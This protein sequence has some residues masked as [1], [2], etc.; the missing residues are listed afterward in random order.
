MQM[1]NTIMYVSAIQ[2][3]FPNIVVETSYGQLT[4]DAKEFARKH[5]ETPQSDMDI[6]MRIVDN[7][8]IVDNKVVGTQAELNAFCND[9]VQYFIARFVISGK[10]IPVVTAAEAQSIL[11]KPKC[12]VCND[13]TRLLRCKRCK[14]VYYCS[15]DHQKEDWTHHK[16]IC[17]PV[18]SKK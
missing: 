14:R 18:E 15:P 12:S 3:G 11:T 7:T 8:I 13:T 6:L 9:I 1:D 16:Q 4:N 17:K 2:I 5:Q 10:P